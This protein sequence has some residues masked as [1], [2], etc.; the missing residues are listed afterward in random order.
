MKKKLLLLL[1]SAVMIC[2]SVSVSAENNVFRETS[3]Q[4]YQLGKY[5]GEPIIWRN[6]VCEDDPNGVLMVSDDILCEKCFDVGNEFEIP[7]S[8]FY[9]MFGSDDWSISCI[10]DWL[11]STADSGQ[12]QWTKYAPTEQRVKGIPGYTPETGEAYDQE[13]GFLHS[14]NFSESERSVIKSV[15]QWQE[16]VNSEQES[17]NG[18]TIPFKPVYQYERGQNGNYVEGHITIDD[19][20]DA[21]S[22]AAMYRLTDTIFFLDMQQLHNM[23]TAFG[24]VAAA[25]EEEYEDIREGTWTRNSGDNWYVLTFKTNAV[26]NFNIGFNYNAAANQKGCVRP[27]FYL[28]ED[29]AMIV[30]GSGTKDDPYVLNGTA[31]TGTEV[32][33]NGEQINFDVEPI[34]END[35]TLV[36][37]RAIFESLDADVTWEQDT[38]TAVAVK[39]GTTIKLQAN[40]NVMLKND[41]E[42]TLDVPAQ[43]VNDRTMIP[44]R[45][46]AEALDAKVDWIGE[47]RRVV[48][49]EDPEPIPVSD[50]NPTWYQ[51]TTQWYK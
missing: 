31:S 49:D 8:S 19:C 1:S 47:L 24:T 46:V 29:T 6:I 27:A 38:L 3:G 23:Y 42:I 4:Y 12:V 39:D 36:G 7:V 26:F 45:A 32:F 25:N 15:T 28:N 20:A 18:N 48:I 41:E 2:T 21:Y 34:T 17:E 33:C 37:M 11:N 51:N 35:R 22:K 43:V 13:K 10:R 50:W 16:V 40:N 9:E 44:L 30:S 5:N 14:D